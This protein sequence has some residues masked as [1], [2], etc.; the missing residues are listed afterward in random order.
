MKRN[1]KKP[2]ECCTESKPFPSKWFERVGDKS[3]NDYMTTRTEI[4]N[5][6]KKGIITETP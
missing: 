4:N 3:H 2:R 6:L 5:V 1:Q